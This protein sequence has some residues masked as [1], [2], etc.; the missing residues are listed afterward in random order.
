MCRFC[1]AGKCF[2]T[3]YG[4]F[5]CHGAFGGVP[6]LRNGFVKCLEYGGAFLKIL[7]CKDLVLAFGRLEQKWSWGW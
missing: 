4:D 1:G 5:D 3:V 7:M 2:R 6:K